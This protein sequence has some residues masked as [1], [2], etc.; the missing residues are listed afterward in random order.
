MF[1]RW[2]GS[3]GSKA[4]MGMWERDSATAT[5][6]HTWR[7]RVACLGMSLRWTIDMKAAFV[8]SRDSPT[9]DVAIAIVP[10]KWR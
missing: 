5:F 2:N 10:P 9:S 3:Q 7:M 1:I 6:G 8:Y 4:I